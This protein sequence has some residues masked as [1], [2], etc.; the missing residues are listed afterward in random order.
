MN[1]KEEILTI[2]MEECAEVIQASSK[3]IRFGGA[4]NDATLEKEIGDLLCMLD[5]LSYYEI[6]DWVNV[7][8]QALAKAKKLKRYSS[9]PE[10]ALDHE[11][12]QSE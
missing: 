10:E 5:L 1:T 3:C 2:L 9:I 4:N 11:I 8:K 12:S 6:I 7:H